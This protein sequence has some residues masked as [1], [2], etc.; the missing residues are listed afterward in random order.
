M[1]TIPGW[2]PGQDVQLEVGDILEG[3]PTP[4]PAH[5]FPAGL[6]TS[7]PIVPGCPHGP[8]SVCRGPHGQDFSQDVA[9]AEAKLVPGRLGLRLT[10]HRCPSDKPISEGRPGTSHMDRAEREA[11][12]RCADRAPPAGQLFR[13]EAERPLLLQP[14]LHGDGRVSGALG[15]NAFVITGWSSMAGPPR[16]VGEAWEIHHAPALAA[17]ETNALETGLGSTLALVYRGSLFPLG[18]EYDSRWLAALPL[19]ALKTPSSVCWPAAEGI[20]FLLWPL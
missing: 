2:S 15:G 3:H 6:A 1:L 18:L 14:P 16:G 17:R 11:Q 10:L 12:P 9:G 19:S 20:V 4:L 5:I 7:A 13:S 8:P